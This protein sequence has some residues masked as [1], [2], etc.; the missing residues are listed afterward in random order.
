MVSTIAGELSADAVSFGVGQTTLTPGEAT[1]ITANRKIIT[2]ANLTLR[3][4]RPEK[5]VEQIRQLVADQGG[6]VSQV[7]VTNQ[8]GDRFQATI[9]LRVD[10]AKFQA[11]LSAAKGVASE[12]IQEQLGTKDV[13]EQYTDMAARLENLKRAEEELRKLLEETR[14]GSGKLEDVM[15]VFRELTNMRGQIE[16]LQGQLNVLSDRVELATLNVTLVGPEAQVA[17][18]DITWSAAGTFRSA[19]RNL[20]EALQWVAGAAIYFA[21]TVLPLVLLALIP[22]WVIYRLAK[23]A[24]TPATA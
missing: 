15:A 23:R 21:V 7:N 22:I 16:S 10:A 17:L 6:H 11:V 20:T 5:A 2:T 13:T 3:V 9:T 19:T 24:R 14:Q 8:S 1:S 12:V 18:A 4:D